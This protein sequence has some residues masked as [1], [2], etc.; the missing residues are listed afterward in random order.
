M[1]GTGFSKHTINFESFNPYP[2]F[3]M[4]LVLALFLKNRI[5]DHDTYYDYKIIMARMVSKLF[6]ITIDDFFRVRQLLVSKKK[7]VKMKE[8]TLS[9]H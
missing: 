6:I 3:L 1:R 8:K 2:N 9:E 4:G 5:S 7:G